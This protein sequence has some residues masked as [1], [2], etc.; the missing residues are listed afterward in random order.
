MTFTFKRYYFI[1]N[2]HYTL[3]SYTSQYPVSQ[4]PES[5]DSIQRRFHQLCQ[6]LID[7]HLLFLET[8][9]MRSLTNKR[10]LIKREGWKEPTGYDSWMTLIRVTQQFWKYKFHFI[11][12]KYRVSSCFKIEVWGDLPY[13]LCFC[14]GR[15]GWLSLRRR[16]HGQ[17]ISKVHRI[18]TV[19]PRLDVLLL[20]PVGW[21]AKE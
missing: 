9:H 18:P 1:H 17:A 13:I 2:F 6:P 15:G 21:T 7:E 20:P 8:L 10:P 12:C 16:Q 19:P 11:I 14:H 4:N 3:R 5:L